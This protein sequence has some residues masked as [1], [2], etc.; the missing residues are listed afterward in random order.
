MQIIPGCWPSDCCCWSLC[1]FISQLHILLH[2]QHL[3]HHWYTCYHRWVDDLLHL[4]CGL[5][6]HYHGMETRACDSESL[7]LSPLLY[8]DTLQSFL[9]HTQHAVVQVIVILILIVGGVYSIV[10]RD[11]FGPALEK[12]YSIAWEE[13]ISAYTASP[14]SSGN[15]KSVDSAVDDLQNQV[16]LCVHTA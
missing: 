4:H 15:E 2:W 6:W 12:E 3:W 14:D 7:F 10:V 13:A 8:L 11:S 5:N 9:F 1:S 16:K